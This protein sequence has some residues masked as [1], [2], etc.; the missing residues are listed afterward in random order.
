MASK[1]TLREYSSAFIIMI[2]VAA[3]AS[4]FVLGP[5]GLLPVYGEDENQGKELEQ[6]QTEVQKAS[7]RVE[8]GESRVQ[9][10]DID[11]DTFFLS[12]IRNVWQTVTGSLGALNSLSSFVID[13]LGLPGWVAQLV[14]IPVIGIIYEIVSLYRGIRT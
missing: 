10:I 4:G 2:V 11:S 1:L 6:F 9:D 7:P 13:V 12:S 8:E 5:N 14:W 3:G